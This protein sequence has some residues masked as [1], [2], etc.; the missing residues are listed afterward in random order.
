[1]I[2]VC[3]LKG[4]QDDQTLPSVRSYLL[5]AREIS[6]ITAQLCIKET[7]F[8]G[9]AS[10][11]VTK[12]DHGSINEEAAA[13]RSHALPKITVPTHG[14]LEGDMKWV[15]CL[16]PISP[17]PK[18]ATMTGSSTSH[19]EV[20]GVPEPLQRDENQ[21]GRE[22]CTIARV[23]GAYDPFLRPEAERENAASHWPSSG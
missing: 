6:C 13:N 5:H 15:L 10:K 1:M 2:S 14:Q 7:P 22:S 20:L 18:P 4:T 16:D 11:F 19:V 12:Q 21:H 17:S 9:R 3:S 23:T 8:G